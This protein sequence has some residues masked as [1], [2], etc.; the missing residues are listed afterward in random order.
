LFGWEKQ[1][2]WELLINFVKKKRAE[3]CFVFDLFDGCLFIK[4]NMNSDIIG[5]E[6]KLLAK[7]VEVDSL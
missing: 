5:L 7:D 4:K 3:N 2:S 1:N 6:K